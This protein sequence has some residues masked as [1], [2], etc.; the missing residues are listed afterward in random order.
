MHEHSEF[1]FSPFIVQFM[2]KKACDYLLNHMN[3]ILGIFCCIEQKL[4]DRRIH[5]VLRC[6][7]SSCSSFI[8]VATYVYER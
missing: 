6:S 4:Q 7:S 3:D 5:E 1:N 2:H 8:F